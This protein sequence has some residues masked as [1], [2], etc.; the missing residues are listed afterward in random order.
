MYEMFEFI[1]K[2]NSADT[3]NAQNRVNPMRN[4]VHEIYGLSGFE[5]I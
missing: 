1:E 2:L 3:L 5:E 4:C